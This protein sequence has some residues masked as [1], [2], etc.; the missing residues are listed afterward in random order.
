[1]II[2][3]E[4]GSIYPKD[5]LANTKIIRIT[6]IISFLVRVG[7]HFSILINSLMQTSLLLVAPVLQL[8]A[9]QMDA[10]CIITNRINWSRIQGEQL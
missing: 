4:P 1:M 5:T 9:S 10:F 3:V 2:P 6:N 7:L 8:G